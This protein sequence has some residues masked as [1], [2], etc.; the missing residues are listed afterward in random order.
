MESYIDDQ[1]K[2]DNV[3]DIRI[4][5]H[6]MLYGDWRRDLKDI[7]SLS[8]E[9]AVAVMSKLLS[10]DVRYIGID[11]YPAGNGSSHVQKI[12]HEVFVEDDRVC[13]GEHP[14]TILGKDMHIVS[15][16]DFGT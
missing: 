2:I 16:F 7:T 12:R 8:E 11:G 5:V 3:E 4:T 1:Y 10:I 14:I 9:Q 15:D 6:P 13:S